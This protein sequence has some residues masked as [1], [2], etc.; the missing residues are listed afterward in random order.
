MAV[1]NLFLSAG[2]IPK[3]A[4]ADNDTTPEGTLQ[5]GEALTGGVSALLFWL[6]RERRPQGCL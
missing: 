4:G 3:G 6:P 2:V 1:V 5:V